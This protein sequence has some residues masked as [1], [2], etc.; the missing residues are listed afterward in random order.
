LHSLFRVLAWARKLANA[1]HI[2]VHG[3]AGRPSGEATRESYTEE[4]VMKVRWMLAAC[5][6]LLFAGFSGTAARAQD[7]RA[8]DQRADQQH[9]QMDA[10]NPKF[11]FASC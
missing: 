8:Q 9:R 11:D 6:A 10:K 4:Y 1:H 7:Q 5:A 2:N 3:P